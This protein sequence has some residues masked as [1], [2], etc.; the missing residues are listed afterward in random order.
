MLSFASR[1][2]RASLAAGLLALL[3][4]AP[5]A[6]AQP[7]PGAGASAPGGGGS[8]VNT[9][10]SI[11]TLE[12][13]QVPGRKF[14][15]H[16]RVSDDAPGS[17]SVTITGAAN[18]SAMCDASGNF[19]AVFSVPAVGPCVAVASDGQNSSAQKPFVLTN[20]APTVSVSAIQRPNNAWTFKGSVGD[21]APAGL[22]VRLS[23]AGLIGITAVV[24]SDG[25]FSVTVTLAPG[26]SGT[27]FATVTD[28]YE[29]TGTG[30]TYFGS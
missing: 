18:G 23:G 20:A 27:V 19:D 13:E 30:Q 2:L 16:G 1:R 14:R 17:C 7:N 25:S 3:A 4:C 24:Q 21:E 22:I 29:L 12:W 9:A 11:V 15:I 8:G 10:P 26:A 28:W 5:S 6:L